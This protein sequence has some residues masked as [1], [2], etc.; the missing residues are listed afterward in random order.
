MR[1]VYTLL[2]Y[3]VDFSMR[4]MHNRSHPNVVTYACMYVCTCSSTMYTVNLK[5]TCTACMHAWGNY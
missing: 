4:I 3:V 2:M 1:L 5:N